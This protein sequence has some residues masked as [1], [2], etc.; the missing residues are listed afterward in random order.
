[1]RKPTEEQKL[2]QRIERADNEYFEFR[3]SRSTFIVCGVVAT[4]F[5]YPVGIIIG[6]YLLSKGCRLAGAC[7]LAV[8]IGIFLYVLL[9]GV[10]FFLP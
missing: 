9:H 1:M 3:V 4:F 7:L 2:K 8:P 5:F 6:I 10:D